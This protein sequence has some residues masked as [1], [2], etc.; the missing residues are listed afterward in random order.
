MKLYYCKMP[1]TFHAQ[2][3]VRAKNEREA[4]KKFRGDSPRLPAGTEVWK[5]TQKEIDDTRLSFRKYNAK[6]PPWARGQL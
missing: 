2:G 1:G 3:P 4:R 6:A 5:T